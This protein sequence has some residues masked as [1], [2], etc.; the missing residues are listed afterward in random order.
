MECQHCGFVT[1]FP[2]EVC[3]KEYG[4]PWISVKDRLP[5]ESQL[6]LVFNQEDYLAD[7]YAWFGDCYGVNFFSDVFKYDGDF[8]VT[9]WMPL[10]E[11]PKESE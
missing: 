5:E 1:V 7:L 11:P 4:S 8:K 10:S 2:C 3:G 6:V 9:H